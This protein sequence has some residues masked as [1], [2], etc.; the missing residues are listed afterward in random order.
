[1]CLNCWVY[2]GCETIHPTQ[3]FASM[4]FANTLRDNMSVVIFDF[5]SHEGCYWP[6]THLGGQKWHEG[7]DLL[8]KVL[9]R[10]FLTTS[11]PLSRSNQI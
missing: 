4:N 11:K 9:N 2:F 1:M 6:K 10:S 8:K 3:K 5:Q 7:V